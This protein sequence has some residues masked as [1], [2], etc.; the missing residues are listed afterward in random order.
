MGTEE[1]QRPPLAFVTLRRRSCDVPD[2]PVPAAL[3]AHERESDMAKVKDTPSTKPTPAED[4][5]DP[6]VVELEKQTAR[7]KARQGLLAARLGAFGSLTP[8]VSDAPQNTVTFGDKAGSLAPWLAQSVLAEVAG[9]ISAAVWENL[10]P[11]TPAA[12]VP[13]PVSAGTPEQRAHAARVA[14]EAAADRAAHERARAEKAAEGAAAD[15]AAAEAA[16]ARAAA[17][18][19]GIQPDE[20]TPSNPAAETASRPSRSSDSVP[21][22]YVV[23]VTDDPDLLSSDVVSQQVNLALKART[24][25]L[26]QRAGALARASTELTQAVNRYLRD[27]VGTSGQNGSDRGRTRDLVQDTLTE[28]AIAAA[29]KGTEAKA[30][31]TSA[32]DG[33]AAAEDAGAGTGAGDGTSAAGAG[34]IGAAVDLVRLLGVDYTIKTAE[35]AIDSALLARLTAGRLA[36]SSRKGAVDEVLLD[37]FALAGESATLNNYRALFTVLNTV[38]GA[39]Q[40]LARA[41]APVAAEAKVYQERA[42]DIEESWAKTDADPKADEGAAEALQALAQEFRRRFEARSRAAEPAEVLL[43]ACTEAVAAVRAELLVLGAADASGV[44]P[45]Q[46][47]CSRDRLHDRTDKDGK[48]VS[49]VLLVQATHAGADVV[50]RRSILG[51]SGRVGYLG[52]A[53]GAWVMVKTDGTVAGG[54]AVEAA[55]HLA[56]DIASGASARNPIVP[57]VGPLPGTDPLE[58]N[59]QSIRRGVLYLALAIALAGVLVPMFLYIMAVKP[60]WP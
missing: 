35:V 44:S 30:A 6:E 60:W 14:A 3:D 38:E 47:A 31:E 43:T 37:G 20:D 58:Q 5:K 1:G 22:P 36:M 53:N 46:R 15:R 33:K 23:F 18:Q 24:S 7:I 10:Y 4:P 51:A 45:L 16:A 11:Q 48:A 29:Q 26:T 9:N 41:V 17:A 27:E 2:D 39:V 42:T 28:V 34:P 57:G 32:A 56:H 40:E 52:G 12:A 49:H 25:E 54:G 59:E 13:A 21:G 19:A 55:S 50:T 8:G